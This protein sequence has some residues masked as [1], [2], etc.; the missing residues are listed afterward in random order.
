M[1]ITS[2]LRQTITTEYNLKQIFIVTF[3]HYFNPYYCLSK[4]LIGKRKCKKSG[5]QMF[6]TAGVIICKVE[7]WPWKGMI[8]VS[9]RVQTKFDSV[10]L[11]YLNIC[12]SVFIIKA[13]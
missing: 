12:Q 5:S 2:G 9:A 8:K 7:R 1:E 11:S 3:F 10:T 13:P 4:M 6:V